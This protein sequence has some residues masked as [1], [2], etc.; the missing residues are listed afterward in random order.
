[1]NAP[2][3]RVP[4]E[5]KIIE[6]VID[7]ETRIAREPVRLHPFPHLVVDDLLPENVR[8]ALDRYWPDPAR[9][10]TSNHFRRGERR[11]SLLANDVEGAERAFWTELRLLTERAGAAVRARFTRHLHDKFRPL[12]GLHWRRRL[13]PIAYA[14]HDA[15]LAHYTGEIAMAPHVDNARLVLNGFVYLDDPDQ[16]TPEPRRGTMLYRSLGFAWPSNTRIPDVVREQFLRE[17]VEVGWRDNR[18]LSYLN[19]PWS[20]HGV[21]KHDLGESRRRLL[22]FGN[23]LDGATANRLLEEMS[24]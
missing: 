15:M 12:L 3:P 13:G 7:I 19:G 1:M 20:F 5:A 2:A 22:M 9:L 4:T 24:R 17:A 6:A 16:P 23:V 14:A 18:L 10:G 21:P 8:L 11:V